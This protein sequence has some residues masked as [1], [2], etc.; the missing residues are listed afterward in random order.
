VTLQKGQT[1]VVQLPAAF[2][3]TLAPYVT[4]SI[5]TPDDHNGWYDA[6]LRACIWRFVAATS[7]SATLD[8]AGRQVCAPGAK[9]PTVIVNEEIDITVHP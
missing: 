5:L 9:C 4:N 2:H 6:S 1:L 7:G 3:W 8:Y